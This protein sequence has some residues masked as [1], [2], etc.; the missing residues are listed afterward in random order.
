MELEGKVLS[1]LPSDAAAVLNYT[2]WI[3]VDALRLSTH[4]NVP[5]SQEATVRNIRNLKSKYFI[6]AEF[7]YKKYKQ[8]HN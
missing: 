3:C 1:L 8:N 5:N 2:I 4:H 7:P 6:T